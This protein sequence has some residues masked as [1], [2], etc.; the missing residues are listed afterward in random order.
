MRR[1]EGASLIEM[2]IVIVIIGISVVPISRLAVTNL[3]NGGRSA[4]TTRALYFGEEVMERIIADYNAPHR[5]PGEN[6]G[7]TNVRA[8]WPGSVSGAPTGLTGFV[9]I[10]REHTRNSVKYVEVTVTVSGP[11]ISDVTLTAW[12]SEQ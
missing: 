3:I 5:D 11:D 10:S 9:T 6:G 4:I 12:L 7:Y 1:E 2:I 8:N